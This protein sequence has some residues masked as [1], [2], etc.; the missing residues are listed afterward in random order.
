MLLRTAKKCPRDSE[1]RESH[2]DL[3]VR[4]RKPRRVGR[5]PDVPVVRSVPRQVV[6]SE[7]LALRVVVLALLAGAVVVEAVERVGAG[8]AEVLLGLVRLLRVLRQ[9]LLQFLTT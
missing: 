4:P 1:A 9:V 5:I 7:S 8:A 3:R 6:G 2:D